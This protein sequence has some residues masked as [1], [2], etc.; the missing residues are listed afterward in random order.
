MRD[1]IWKVDFLCLVKAH[2]SRRFREEDYH[3]RRG[4]KEGY[5]RR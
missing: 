4:E 5:Y 3:I 2:S 1:I